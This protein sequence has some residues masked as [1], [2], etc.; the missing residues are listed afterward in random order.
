MSEARLVRAILAALNARPHTKA[1]KIHGNAYTEAGTPDVLGC[2]QRGAFAI[3]VKRPG[4]RVKPG[5][6]QEKRLAEWA[7]A[8][9]RVGVATTVDEATKI[10]DE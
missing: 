7:V 6:I 1:I 2:D 10:V 4:E 9:A 3:E 8:G 5:G